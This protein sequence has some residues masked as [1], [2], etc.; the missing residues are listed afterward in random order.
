MSNDLFENRAISVIARV[1]RRN[2]CQIAFRRQGD[3]ARGFLHI[4]DPQVTGSITADKVPSETTFHCTNREENAVSV[5]RPAQTVA[6]S[7]AKRG[8]LAKVAN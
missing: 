4:F 3:G 1:L 2:Q 7:G 5:N 6:I 8:I